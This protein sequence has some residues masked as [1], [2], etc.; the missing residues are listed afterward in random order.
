MTQALAGAATEQR[1]MD[2]LDPWTDAR[3]RRSW[4]AM[5]GAADNRYTRDLVPALRQNATP[6]LLIC[7]SPR[8]SRIPD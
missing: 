8:R 7:G 6:K 3:A 1:I 4:M 5:V 2:Y